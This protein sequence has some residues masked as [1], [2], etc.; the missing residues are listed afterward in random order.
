[1]TFVRSVR[2]FEE[3]AARS[4]EPRYAST[5]TILPMRSTPRD[6]WSRYFPRSSRATAIVSRSEN[7]GPS[8]SKLWRRVRWSSRSGRLLFFAFLLIVG[9]LLRFAPFSRGGLFLDR[10]RRFLNLRA[11]CR[12]R[13]FPR[14]GRLLCFRF[15]L[16][17]LQL[18]LSCVA[19]RSRCF[20]PRGRSD[21]FQFA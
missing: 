17:T 3:W 8:L 5:S 6:V 11:G 7:V 2:P 10:H 21:G 9:F 1:M 14:S 4:C 16:P 20:G 13:W 15:D 19:H 18:A 12:L